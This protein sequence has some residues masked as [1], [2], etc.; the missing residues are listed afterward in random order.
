[1]SRVEFDRDA[2]TLT[3]PET[4]RL[5]RQ[6]GFRVLETS[7]LFF[8]P[9]CLAALRPLEERLASLCLGG[10]YQVPAERPGGA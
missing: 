1:M 8:F 10:Q 9:R 2:I 6:G 4:A 7:Y 3:P 5:L